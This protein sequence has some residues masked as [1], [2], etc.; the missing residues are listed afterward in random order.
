MYTIKAELKR[1]QDNILFI[2]QYLQELTELRSIAIKG[3][4]LSSSEIE[5]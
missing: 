3:I 5:I 2:S 1:C 4:D